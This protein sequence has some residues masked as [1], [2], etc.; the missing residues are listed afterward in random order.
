MFV[1]WLGKAS[2]VFVGH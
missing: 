1:L 2:C